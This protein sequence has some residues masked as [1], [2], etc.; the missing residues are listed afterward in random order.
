MPD[1]AR[2]IPDQTNEERRAPSNLVLLCAGH[3][4][5]I[6][7]KKHEKKWVAAALKKIKA[8]H[9]KK[10]KGLD[11]S[12]RQ[13][14]QDAGQDRRFLLLLAN[15]QTTLRRGHTQFHDHATPPR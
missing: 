10:F 6:D 12:L 7:S 8:D 1:G 11:G 14:F 13:A 9:E 15:H 2:F 5:Q 3:H 4:A